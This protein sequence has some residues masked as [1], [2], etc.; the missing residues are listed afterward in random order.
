MTAIDP[1][2][3]RFV[4]E[5]RRS[6]TG[7]GPD[8]PGLRG[9]QESVEDWL[10]RV[11][12]ARREA[13]RRAV[14]HRRLV[15]AAARTLYGHTAAELVDTIAELDHLD[16]TL[17]V[18]DRWSLA[19]LVPDRDAELPHTPAHRLDPSQHPIALRVTT[20]PDPRAVVIRLH[21]GAFWMGGG[22]VGRE[23]DA[24]LIDRVAHGAAA[25]VIDLDYR[26]APEYP[27]PAPVVDTLALLDR[28]RADGLGLVAPDVPVALL[29][30]SS[31]ANVAVAAARLDRLRGCRDVPGLQ[32][33]ALIVPSVQLTTLPDGTTPDPQ[34]WESRHELLDSYLA[35][36]ALDDPWASPALDTAS[37]A[38]PPTRIAVAAYD[39]I[40]AGGRELSAAIR[41]SGGAAWCQDYPMTHT[42]AAPQTEAAMINDTA[43]F[44]ADRLGRV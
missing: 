8:H 3:A 27:F 39:E 32:A 20:P 21:G 1:T 2:T 38:L 31:G 6:T 22:S 16:L 42:I 12:T 36:L 9:S 25:A 24:A 33:L 10:S 34:A 23:I 35:G 14:E 26:L 30:T 41:R 44:L 17:T 40:A 28:L 4:A 37:L 29:G 18:D 5:V 43:E 19:D 13:D 11:R 15:D 7:P